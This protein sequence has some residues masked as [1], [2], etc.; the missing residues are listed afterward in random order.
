MYWQIESI[1]ANVFG[2]VYFWSRMLLKKLICSVKKFAHF[3]LAQISA[4]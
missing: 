1:S 3:L 4:L 2:V